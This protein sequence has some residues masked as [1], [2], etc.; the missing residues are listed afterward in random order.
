MSEKKIEEPKPRVHVTPVV[1]RP[2]LVEFLLSFWG[3]NKRVQRIEVRMLRQRKDGGVDRLTPVR[4]AYT[5][6]PTAPPPSQSDIVSMA[7]EI[8]RDL[9]NH[10]NAL[11]KK[12]LYGVCPYDTG[13][14]DDVLAVHLIRCFPKENP[15]ESGAD[16]TVEGDIVDLSGDGAFTSGAIGMMLKYSLEQNRQSLED[17]RYFIKTNRELVEST[18]EHLIEMNEKMARLVGEGFDRQVNMMKATEALLSEDHKRRLSARWTEV[19]VNAA[20]KTAD[21]VLGLLPPMINRMAG[22]EVIQTKTSIES[23]VVSQFIASVTPE[24]AREAFGYQGEGQ[25]RYAG[26]IF[27]EAQGSLLAQIAKCQVPAERIDDLLPGGP[28]EIVT[29]Q[30]E[31]A[32]STFDM[33]QLWPLFDIIQQRMQRKVNEASSTTATA[34]TPPV[35][36]ASPK[37]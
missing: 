1:T 37:P 35:P 23:S 31:R 36:P 17:R 20:E 24:Q 28:L 26:C 16:A 21:M 34:T 13:S 15:N 10:C 11:Q 32:R 4:N 7:N 12:Q 3:E 18:N 14:G 30:Q 9:Q 5:F 6:Q 8:M 33:A 22:K 29:A 2:D 27:S 19:G 25:P